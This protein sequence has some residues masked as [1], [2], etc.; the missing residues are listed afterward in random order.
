MF[1]QR[2]VVFSEQ[3]LSRQ[4]WLYFI[5]KMDFFKNQERRPEYRKLLNNCIFRK[6][7]SFAMC[8]K[9]FYAMLDKIQSPNA[10]KL[11]NPS[12]TLDDLVEVFDNLEDPLLEE[13]SKLLTSITKNPLY[14]RFLHT[15]QM[16]AFSISELSDSEESVFHLHTIRDMCLVCTV[17]L[18]LEALRHKFNKI[19]AEQKLKHCLWVSSQTLFEDGTIENIDK[20]LKNYGPSRQFFKYHAHKGEEPVWN[21]YNFVFGVLQLPKWATEDPNN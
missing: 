2:D 10:A 14:R 17:S 4:F 6:L 5:E 21:I 9:E 13:P 19:G 8:I 11:R 1:D 16:A 12:N 20:R 7:F 15:E 18:G 3:D